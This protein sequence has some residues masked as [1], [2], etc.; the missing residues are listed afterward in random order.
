MSVE[1]SDQKKVEPMFLWT[2]YRIIG[3]GLF[4]CFLFYV[5]NKSEY[6]VS[7]WH[8]IIS[9]GTFIFGVFL[10]RCFKPQGWCAVF[11]VILPL[12]AGVV[13]AAGLFIAPKHFDDE[14]NLFLGGLASI[15]TAFAAATFSNIK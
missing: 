7:Y 9:I 4:F 1:N 8:I 10:G 6:Q 14:V 11:S 3:V 12:F 13:I 2:L 5:G 15:F